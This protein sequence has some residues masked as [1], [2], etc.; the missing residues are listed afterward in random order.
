MPGRYYE[1]FAVDEVIVHAPEHTVTQDANATFC[2]LTLNNQPLHLDE[3]AARE[4]PYDKLLVNGLLT[5]S[6]GVGMSVEDLTVGTLIANL[7]YAKVE[8]PKPVFPGDT[9]RARSKVLSKRR[10]SK[11]ER[12]LV[13]LATEVLNHHD[14]VVCRFERTVL[15]QVRD[16]EQEE[17]AEA[18]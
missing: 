8:H 3:E 17:E 7:A 9:L 16:P 5:F 1:E 18:S 10:T 4:G 15:V 12:G 14:N 11:K 2:R 13:R 6:L